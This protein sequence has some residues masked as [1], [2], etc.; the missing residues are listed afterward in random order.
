MDVPLE[1]NEDFTVL[2]WRVGLF[3][4]D[5][6]K[7]TI[8][9]T[10]CDLGGRPGPLFTCPVEN[11][12]S[13]SLGDC[14]NDVELPFLNGSFFVLLPFGRPFFA[15]LGVMTVFSFIAFWVS[16]MTYRHVGQNHSFSGIF[17]SGGER[18]NM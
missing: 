18:Q 11:V 5:L 2:L 16:E 4:R 13:N 12:P 1:A 3:D 6:F 8:L 14:V 7:S 15:P 10:F 17:F 9:E